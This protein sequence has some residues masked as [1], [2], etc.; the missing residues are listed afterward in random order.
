MFAHS[1]DATAIPQSSLA[2]VVPSDKDSPILGSVPRIGE[3]GSDPMFTSNDDAILRGV[4]PRS[5]NHRTVHQRGAGS[6]TL[7]T[8]W[9]LR[10][11]LLL[12]K[13]LTVGVKCTD[14][15]PVVGS[16]V[17]SAVGESINGNG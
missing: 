6:A 5:S 10:S 17:L 12:P 7:F 15:I 4:L 1:A 9:K 13:L 16:G 14:G 8:D 3:L 2:V 11:K